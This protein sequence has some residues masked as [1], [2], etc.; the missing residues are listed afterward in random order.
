M[1]RIFTLDKIR[2]SI[3]FYSFLRYI[4]KTS[5]L[6]CEE[7]WPEYEV[8]YFIKTLLFRIQSGE[9]NFKKYL[10]PDLNTQ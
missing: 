4:Y 3:F 8:K 2:L 5:L 10:D 7:H 9:Q 1:L 6:V